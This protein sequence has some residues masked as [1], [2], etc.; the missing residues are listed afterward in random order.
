MIGLSRSDKT[1]MWKIIAFAEEKPKC[2]L[3][4]EGEC[5]VPIGVAGFYIYC[6]AGI[7]Q[8]ESQSQGYAGAG[9]AGV[10]RWDVP[11]G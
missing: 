1:G 10:A 3:L 7:G 11:A 4:A 6:L 9:A 5:R 8:F 2:G